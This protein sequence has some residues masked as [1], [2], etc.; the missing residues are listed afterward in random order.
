MFSD[1]LRKL[2]RRVSN[3]NFIIYILIY[4]FKK[5]MRYIYNFNMLKTINLSMFFLRKQKQ[6]LYYV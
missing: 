4:N 5:I 6:R 3:F 1:I 2:L